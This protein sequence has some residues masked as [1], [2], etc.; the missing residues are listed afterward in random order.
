M[1]IKLNFAKT[2]AYA[3]FAA[4]LPVSAHAAE[5]TSFSADGTKYEYTTK[6]VNGHTVITGKTSDGKAFR[7]RVGDTAVVGEFGGQ[8]VRFQRTDA[9]S[10]QVAIR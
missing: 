6:V 1:T 2:F 9:R 4:F 3:A 7:L 8:P 5:P 10:A